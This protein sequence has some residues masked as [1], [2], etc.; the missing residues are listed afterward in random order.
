MK[1]LISLLIITLLAISPSSF[2]EDAREKVNFPDMMKQHM[3]ENMRD[4][5]LAI[6][7]IQQF[8]ALAEFDKAAEVAEQRLGLS[9][10]DNHS[11][12]HMAQITVYCLS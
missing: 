6:S 7:E 12:A 11:A 2:A 5:L 10:L 1:Q 8:M 4:H 3:M 9:S